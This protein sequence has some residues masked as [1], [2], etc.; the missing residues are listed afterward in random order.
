[1]KHRRSRWWTKRKE[2]LASLLASERKVED[3]REKDRKR[4]KSPRAK[5]RLGRSGIWLFF[6]LILMQNWFCIDAAVGRLEPKGKAKVLE[7]I[8]VSDAVEGTFVDLD[9]RTFGRTK[10]EN[11]QRE[12]KRSKGVDRT[13][14]RKEEERLRCAMLSGSAWSTE[15]KYMRR[16]K[17]KCDIL[18]GNEHRLRK[19]EMEEQFN[20][21][22]KEGWRFAASAARIT[23]EMAGD[24]DREHTSGGVF[25]CSRK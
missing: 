16:Y 17:G 6:L 21:E 11:H 5:L 12:R 3:V 15:R 9:G 19:E 24:E 8:I 23:D 7:I 4:S 13:E 22:A 1:M 25:C 18:F 14:M 10:K 20:R 2:Q